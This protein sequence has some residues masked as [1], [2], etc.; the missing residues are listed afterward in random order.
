M[1]EAAGASSEVKQ[2]CKQAFDAASTLTLE[3][4]MQKRC[5]DYN[6][7]LGTLNDEDGYDCRKCL[8]RG[9]IAEVTTG[10]TTMIYET[11]V[12]C[13]CM[14]IRRSIK[15][16]KRSGLAESIKRC[17]FER[18]T[19]DEEWQRIAKDHA[20]RFCHEEPGRWFFIGGSVGSGKTHLCTAIARHFLYSVNVKYMLWTTESTRLKAVINDDEEY[21]RQ[22]NVLKT[23]DVLYIDDFF[24]PTNSDDRTKQPTPADVRLAYDIINYRYVNRLTTII[25]SERYLSELMD[26]DEATASRIAERSTGYC[27][28]ITRDR[29]KNFRLTMN[30]TEL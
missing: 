15:R 16:M 29:S 14:Q 22:M 1:M 7:T 9:D 12:E 24:K 23:A 11:H 19:T 20:E 27:L 25:S 18:F 28:T 4:R 21:D 8:N 5:D 30:G 10:N 13:S 2:S 17:T 6:R 3:E 26:I